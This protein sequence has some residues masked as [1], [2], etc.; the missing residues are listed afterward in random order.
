MEQ[1]ATGTFEV[2][3]SPQVDEH[4]SG[5]LMGRLLIDK[6]FH[7]GLD[8]TSK[9]QMLSAGTAIKGSAGYVGLAK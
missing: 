5:P 2:K 7:G 6:T 3:L 9:G 1:I 4:N 8:G